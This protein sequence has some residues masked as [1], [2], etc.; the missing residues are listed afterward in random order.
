VDQSSKE[1]PT[2]IRSSYFSGNIHFILQKELKEMVGAGVAGFKC[3]LCPSGVE[4]FP[5]VTKEDVE[6]ALRELEG[7]NSV[8]AV[9]CKIFN[10]RDAHKAMT[11]LL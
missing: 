9:C 8:L 3:F 2:T 6:A 4:E 10:K 7:T 11:L 5:E 1:S